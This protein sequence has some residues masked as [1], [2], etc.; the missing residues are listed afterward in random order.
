MKLVTIG[1]PVF[2][3]ENYLQVALDSLR[4]QDYE[5]LEILV[6]DNASTDAS[7][8]IAEAAAAQ[9]A[10]VK[11]L[12]APENLGAAWNYNR[13]VEAASGE[14]FK[15]A[16]HDDV[17]APS[18]ISE[19]VAELDSKPNVVV[20]H[21]QAL[22]IDADGDV[23][24]TYDEDMNLEFGGDVKRASAMLW[25]VGM[26]HAVFG[27]MRTDVLRRTPLIQP[28]DSSDVAL[29]AEL[30]LRGEIVQTPGRLFHRRRHDQDS[31]RAN[32]SSEDV[33]KWF[34]P[35]GAQKGRTTPL[36]KSYM[37]SARSWAPNWRSAVAASAMFATVGPL[38][39]LRWHRRE[40]RKRKRGR[41]A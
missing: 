19:C 18:F 13:L 22:I 17:C 1:V 7:A 35:T 27:V 10:R 23:L 14:Y 40:R 32:A 24:K 36:L 38:T 26:C 30:A 29:L 41:A 12:A 8:A 37:R 16:A 39:E 4:A 3:G 5:N 2:N 33:A 21:P 34:A 11:L 20:A 28:F 15:W 6:A 31:R 9:D 25:R